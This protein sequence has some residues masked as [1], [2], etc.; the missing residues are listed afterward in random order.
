MSTY[1]DEGKVSYECTT[2]FDDYDTSDSDQHWAQNKNT[3][4]NYLLTI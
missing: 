1:E 4:Q 3:D 2:Y